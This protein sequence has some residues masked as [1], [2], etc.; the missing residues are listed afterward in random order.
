M[1]NGKLDDMINRKLSVLIN[2]PLVEIGRAS[3]LTWLC[4]G[5]KIM[6]KDRN[7]LE[8]LKSKYAL[9]IQCPWRF[10]KNRAIIAASRDIFIPKSDFKD[11]KFDWEKFGSN[12]FD[13]NIK[14]INNIISKS[15]TLVTKISSDDMGG[16]NIDFQDDL[17]MELF[18]DCSLEK[19]FWRFIN[20]ENNCDHLIVFDSED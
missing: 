7:G 10:I 17:K 12:H 2:Q 8:S 18:P 19:E 6:I 11:N 9:N 4:F 13:D 16:L 5:K 1:G 20:F 3:G 15:I 14:K